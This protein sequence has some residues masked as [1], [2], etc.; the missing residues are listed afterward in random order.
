MKATWYR[1]KPKKGLLVRFNM[2]DDEKTTVYFR[3]AGKE[4]YVRYTYM[5]TIIPKADL[6]YYIEPLKEN[7]EWVECSPELSESIEVNFTKNKV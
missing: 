7:N 1:A 6:K 4:I 5:Q 2:S 3:E